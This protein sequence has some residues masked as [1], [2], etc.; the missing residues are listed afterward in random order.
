MVNAW[1]THLKQYHMSHPK[2]T[3]GEAMKA[4]KSSY[5]K[6]G[7]PKLGM[8][9]KR[10]QRGGNPAAAI[11]GA[12]QGVSD[13]ATGLGGLIQ[14]G[15]TQDGTYQTMRTNNQLKNFGALKQ[16]RSMGA[17]PSFLTDEQLWSQAMT[18]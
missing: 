6:S 2:L 3:Y 16:L 5:K 15:M 11:A 7:K 18:G 12:V 9:R 17:I 1:L 14:T 8:G 4:A 13:L 10:G